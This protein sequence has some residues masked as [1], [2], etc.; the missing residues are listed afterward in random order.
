MKF[1]RQLT[2]ILFVFGLASF[3]Q[4]QVPELINNEEFRPEAKA[5][6]DAIYNFKPDQADKKLMSWKQKYPGHPIWTLLE[7]MK[8]W[9]K[10]LS[11]LEDTTHDEQ[12]IDMMKKA[13]Y[14]AGK[15]LHQQPLHADGLLI[16]AISNGYLAR[17]HANRSEWLTSIN[18]GRDAMEAHEYL[19]E[20]QPDFTDLKLA[21]GLK[22]Y[23]SAY[24]PEAYPVVKT[25]SWALPEGDKQKGIEFLKEASK[26]AVF[27]AAEARYFLGNIHFNYEK[28][29]SIAARHFKNLHQSYPDN[30]FYSRLLV[31][32]LF[33][34][35]R[36]SEAMD[37]I[38][39]TL[40][41]WEKYDLPHSYVLKE[42]LFTWQGRIFERNGNYRKAEK[43]YRKA[44]AAGQELPNTSRRS[45]HQAS[46]YHLGSLLAR[47]LDNCSEGSIYLRKVREM[48]AETSYPQKSKRVLEDCSEN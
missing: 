13:N 2:I 30:N 25:V 8:F 18:Y 33:S 41:R 6:V 35:D 27:A 26:D 15:L 22:L 47:Q 28:K 4:A 19:L 11:D 29:Y 31:K 24:L 32:T 38:N 43:S 34:M 21:E 3:S 46:G 40:N 20:K 36:H 44:F 1:C 7:G 48:D 12:F 16:K 39:S 37:V 17:H 23:Y 45:F 14:E 9:W 5:A 10:V 42:E